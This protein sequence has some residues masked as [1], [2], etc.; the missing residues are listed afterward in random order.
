MFILTLLF[1]LIEVNVCIMFMRNNYRVI[2][3]QILVT[4][5]ATVYTVKT[6]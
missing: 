5:F 3:K 6:R 4:Q 1:L 2:A